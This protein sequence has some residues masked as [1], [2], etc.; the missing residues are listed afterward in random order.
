MAERKA[1]VEFTEREVQRVA[2]AILDGDAQ[3]ALEV[4]ARVVK[5]KLEAATRGGCRPVFEMRG[6]EGPVVPP[7]VEKE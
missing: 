7:R 1:V 5:P 4:L 2:Q 3:A 6:V